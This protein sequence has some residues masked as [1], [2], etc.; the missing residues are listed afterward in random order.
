MRLPRTERAPALLRTEQKWLPVLAERLPLPTP[1][2]VR[3]GKP[4][5]LFEHTWTIT[6]WVEGDPADYTP[7]T[8]ADSAETLGSFLKA[9][10]EQA[11]ADAPANPT[12]GIPLTR[13]RHA[14]DGWSEVIADDASTDAA[15]ETWEKALA[16]PAWHGAP[17]WLHA[18]LHPANV[19]VKNGTLSGVIDFGEMCAGDPATDLSAAWILLPAGTASRF[20]DSYEGADQAT[21]ARA[22]GWAVLRALVLI[23]I[24]RNGRLGLPGGKP[25]WEPA[26]RA[27]LERALAH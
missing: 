3:I 25:T 16:A 20:F 18:D 10:H 24:G 1:V 19:V 2:P 13:I 6:R 21:I 22:R 14:F 27:A 11:P 15:R 12:R 4:S 9:L 5:D 26:G 23:S 17:T 8:R 7:I